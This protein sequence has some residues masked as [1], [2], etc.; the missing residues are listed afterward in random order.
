MKIEVENAILIKGEEEYEGRWN[1]WIMEE[2]IVISTYLHLFCL[3]H[4]IVLFSKVLQIFFFPFPCCLVSLTWIGFTLFVKVIVTSTANKLLIMIII[5]IKIVMIII[6]AI[7]IMIVAIIISSCNWGPRHD[8]GGHWKYY[9]SN[10]LK[11]IATKNEENSAHKHCAHITK[12]APNLSKDTAISNN[13]ISSK[14][15]SPQVGRHATLHLPE[16]S[17][18]RLGRWW[19]QISI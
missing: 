15:F 9:W 2:L 6:M 5:I 11:T 14:Y 18:K 8:K 10:P 12:S 17:C 16:V 3:I 1:A 19:Y 13:I 4:N 7:V